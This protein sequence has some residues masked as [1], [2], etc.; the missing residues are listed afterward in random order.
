MYILGISSFDHDSAATILRDG[1]I[2][3]AAQE[4]RF[5]RKKNDSSFPENSIDF[6]LEYT[7]IKIDN[8]D[9]IAFYESSSEII[10]DKFP[11]EKIHFVKHNFAHAA[12]AFFPSPFEKAAVITLDGEGDGISQSTFFA[13]CPSI[14]GGF[15]NQP[16]MRA[17][18]M[19]E[20][21]EHPFPHSI[22]YLYSAFTQFLG[23]RVGFGE[24]KV[25]GLAPYG[26]PKFVNLIFEHLVN[27]NND[28]SFT[29]NMEYF[30][31]SGKNLL[32]TEKF[33]KLFDGLPRDPDNELSQFNADIAGSIQTAAEII[34][35]KVAD[36]AYKITK[37]ENLCLAGGVALNCVANGK[38]LNE[39]KFKSIWVQP[40]AGD[41]GG[42]IGA[43]LFVYHEV[44]NNERKSDGTTDKMK[45]AL[46]GPD[47]SENYIKKF[48]DKNKITAKRFDDNTLSEKIAELIDKQK[49]I[50]LFRGR[51]EFGPRALGNRSILADARSSKMQTILNKKIKCRESFRPFAPA[52]LSERA[53]EYFESG[54]SSPYMLFVTRIKEKLRIPRNND[55]QKF[56][57]RVCKIRSPFPAITHIDYS[58]RVQT[59]DKKTNPFFYKVIK[60]FDERTG[61][62]MV[63]NTSFNFRDEPIVCTPEDAYRCFL[64]TGI[65][66]L[67]LGN[68]LISRDLPQM[69][70]PSAE[71]LTDDLSG[72]TH[73]HSK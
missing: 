29:L 16:K 54:I 67:V 18:C 71:K 50:G 57:R 34:I 2:I 21:T 66:F 49:I 47:F 35:L 48:I 4:E 45:G 73:R 65:D 27:L 3:A 20:L 25:M 12:S 41:A 26:K 5:S 51:M 1:E 70:P 64:R 6:C 22:G 56:E 30:D 15:D 28:G 39:S 8:V 38:L 7:N 11:G 61:C 23:F 63:I 42:A 36:H 46:L 37:C 62:G 13:D 43:A 32:T 40:A 44:L 9:A 17:P 33:Y 72:A 60:A 55:E 19:Q 68:Y 14:R 58:A 69:N 59:V 10:K 53:G 24:Y 31:F 52:C